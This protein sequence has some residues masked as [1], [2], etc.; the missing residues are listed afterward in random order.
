[1]SEKKD[2][3][4]DSN[5]IF[6]QLGASSHTEDEREENDYYAT[7]PRAIHDLIQVE[8]KI[9]NLNVPIWEC[10]CGGGHL[11]NEL[12][13]LGYTVRCSDII[14]RT[15]GDD[16]EILDFLGLDQR[17]FEEWNGNIVTNPPYKYCTEFVLRALD[18]V[19]EDNYVCMFLKLQTLEGKDRYEKL[20]KNNPPYRV[21]VYVSRI[22]CGKN[23]VFTGTSA[24]C[25]AW[26]IWKKGY[27]GDTVIRWIN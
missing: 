6:K 15:G 11:S 2:W 16:V 9:F 17:C 7:D 13:R 14:N 1:M 27:K 19:N 25:Y 18:L 23:G 26:F 22:Q 4:G 10:A 20:F 21:Y 5:S 12:K 8:P 24:V 3:T